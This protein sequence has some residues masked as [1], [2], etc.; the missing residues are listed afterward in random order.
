MSPK[1]R[2]ENREKGTENIRDLPAPFG[3]QKTEDAFAAFWNAFPKKVGL[4]ESPQG[5][6]RRYQG[7]CLALL[8]GITTL[9][10]VSEKVSFTKVI[11]RTPPLRWLD[12]LGRRPQTPPVASPPQEP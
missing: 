7:R 11:E 2:K 1:Q 10:V 4:T 9:T 5:I 3:L 12:M 8:A 6:C